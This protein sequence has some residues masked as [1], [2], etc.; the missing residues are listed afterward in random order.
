MDDFKAE[1]VAT[2]ESIHT[3]SHESKDTHSGD[4]E[5]LHEDDESCCDCECEGGSPPS[6]PRCEDYEHLSTDGTYCTHCVPGPRQILLLDGTCSDCPD[7][8]FRDEAIA[9]GGFFTKCVP[10][11]CD[12]DSQ[13]RYINGTC[14]ECPPET[15]P[16]PDNT[17]C[18]FEDCN[19]REA[20]D[21]TGRCYECED[22]YHVDDTGYNCV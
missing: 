2:I 21:G 19:D 5:T 7:Y 16:N 3:T 9:L 17:A 10:S 1:E 13:I 15:F 14:E 8:S 20:K 4:G 18:I 6:T 22:Y 12:L 11:E